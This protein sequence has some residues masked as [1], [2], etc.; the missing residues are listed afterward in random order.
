EHR[1]DLIRKPNKITLS[2]KKRTRLP[3]A[4]FPFLSIVHF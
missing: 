2:P 1:D 4:R 3:K